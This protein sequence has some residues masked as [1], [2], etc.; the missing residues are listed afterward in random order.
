MSGQP[1]YVNVLVLVVCVIV[2]GVPI[3]VV[4][5][6]VESFYVFLILVNMQTKHSLSFCLVLIP[7]LFVLIVLICSI[8]VIFIFSLVILYVF[9]IPLLFLVVRIFIHYFLSV[10]CAIVSY[11]VSAITV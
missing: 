5:P 7:S 3:L 9:A 6:P 11:T 1:S 10:L 2:G 4:A 8:F